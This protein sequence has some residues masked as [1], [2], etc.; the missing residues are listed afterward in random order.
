MVNALF[1]YEP[2]FWQ[3]Q[4]VSDSED[5]LC[6][7][8]IGLRSSSGLQRYLSATSL[9]T[10][11]R[12]IICDYIHVVIIGS[13]QSDRGWWASSQT[14]MCETSFLKPLPYT[15]GVSCFAQGHYTENLC[16]FKLLGFELR[17]TK[18]R[19]I[20]V[21]DLAVTFP[22]YYLLVNLT[23][24]VLKVNSTPYCVPY[25]QDLFE[26]WLNKHIDRWSAGYSD[27]V[28][29]FT[30]TRIRERIQSNTRSKMVVLIWRFRK[31]IRVVV[32]PA[33]VLEYLK[34]VKQK[35]NQRL[36]DEKRRIRVLSSE[37]MLR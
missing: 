24:D 2:Q 33:Y 17:R 6:L 10:V 25:T 18:S 12:Q 30:N 32:L 9:P 1:N 14:W 26:S 29:E 35:I 22:E 13:R 23:D 19:Q 5:E 20:K 21:W 4:K 8:S 7:S 16:L 36:L 37:N 3:W 11:L 15:C 28:E 31:A 27:E 34:L